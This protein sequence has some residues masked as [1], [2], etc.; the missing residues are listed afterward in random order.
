MLPLHIQGS[1]RFKFGIYI[2]EIIILGLGTQCSFPPLSSGF[3]I[4]SCY[5]LN[6]S[7]CLHGFNFAS[8]RPVCVVASWNSR[9]SSWFVALQ[10]RVSA[11]GLV[12]FG[13]WSVP[14]GLMSLGCSVHHRLVAPEYESLLAWKNKDFTQCGK[15]HTS[16][17]WW[18][19]SARIYDNSRSPWCHSTTWNTD[20]PWFMTTQNLCDKPTIC[21]PSDYTHSAPPALTGFTKRRCNVL[22]SLETSSEKI[23]QSF[24]LFLDGI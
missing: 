1:W 21:K 2:T 12:Q 3:L 16:T 4:T 18:I 20:L 10:T 7:R 9:A 17:N 11:P 24:S 13:W 5:S 8:L 14:L 19:W 6:C 22:T 15:T 23:F